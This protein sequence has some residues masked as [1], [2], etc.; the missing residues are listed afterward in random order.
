ME[1]NINIMNSVCL[2]HQDRPAVARCKLCLKPICEECKTE[3]KDG[4]F[5]GEECKTKA[6]TQKETVIQTDLQ[7]Q[8]DRQKQEGMWLKNLLSFAI[9]LGGIV[10]VGYI[11]WHYLLPVPLKIQIQLLI[12]SVLKR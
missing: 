3:T 6:E 1:R 4:V 9:P 2:R 11:A 7:L 5:C 8:L 10:I 12:H